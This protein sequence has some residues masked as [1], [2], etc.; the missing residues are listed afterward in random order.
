M[1]NH[2]LRACALAL[3]TDPGRKDVSREERV[4]GGREKYRGLDACT[5]ESSGSSWRSRDGEGRRH[6]WSGSGGSGGRI[7]Q[8]HELVWNGS[9]NWLPASSD[10]TSV[11]RLK[12]KTFFPCKGRPR[13]KNLSAQRGLSDSTLHIGNFWQPDF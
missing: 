11:A 12:A 4:K 9:V 7:V 8:K 3:Q 5:T 13:W 1:A 6:C 10:D 2:G